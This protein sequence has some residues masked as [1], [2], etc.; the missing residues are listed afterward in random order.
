MDY[1]EEQIKPEYYNDDSHFAVQNNIY[2]HGWKKSLSQEQA[3]YLKDAIKKFPDVLTDD[4][5]DDLYIK[6]LY[7]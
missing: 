5:L 6:S 3:E 1:F 4:K 2:K 7:N